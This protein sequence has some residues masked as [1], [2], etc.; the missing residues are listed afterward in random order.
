MWSIIQAMWMCSVLLS[1]KK[2]ILAHITAKIDIK[3]T[4][5][6][7]YMICFDNFLTT[8]NLKYHLR[9]HKNNNDYYTILETIVGKTN[10]NIHYLKPN[11]WP[12]WF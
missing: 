10:G 2:C 6:Y 3:L 5:N 9:S 11:D 1:C 7:L 4:L 12:M 8:E